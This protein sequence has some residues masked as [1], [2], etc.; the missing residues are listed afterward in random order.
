MLTFR[1]AKFMARALEGAL[2]AKNVAVSHGERLDMVAR[3]FGLKDW[4]VLAAQAK[5]R[6][7]AELRRAMKL[8][9]WAF[10]A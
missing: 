10:Q 1:G 6:Q 8:K 9:A 2:R 3:Q 5:R 4:N 7:A